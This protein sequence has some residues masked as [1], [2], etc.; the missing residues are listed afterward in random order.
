MFVIYQALKHS[1]RF[2]LNVKV[3]KLWGAPLWVDAVSRFWWSWVPAPR[4]R[5]VEPAVES[6]RQCYRPH[7]SCLVPPRA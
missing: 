7:G 3:M 5:G 2:T 6:G 1:P 4:L